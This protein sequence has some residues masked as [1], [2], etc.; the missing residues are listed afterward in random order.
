MKGLELSRRFFEELALPRLEREEPDLLARAAFGLA[1]EGSECLGF[2][3]E[4]SRD[5]DWGPG[6]CIWLDAADMASLGDRAAAFYASLP[7]AYLGCER[8]RETAETAGRVGVRET[9][10]FY[11]RYLGLDRAP[12]DLNEWFFAPEEGLSTAVSGA[13]F[14]D[15]SGAFTAIRREILAYYPEDIR[16]K[17]LAGRCALAAQAGQYN[18]P[19]C[20]R[21]GE[22]VAAM[23]ALSQF[24]E[25]AMR[26]VF[27]LNRRYM[28]YYKWAHRALREL[29]ADRPEMRTSCCPTR[30]AC[31]RRS[32]P[33]PCAVCI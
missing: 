3:D 23:L 2:D 4:L 27:L 17:K 21:R 19:R 8:L 18:Y 12:R 9:G 25:Q 6:F 24:A 11:R 7:R 22:G 32:A 1:G 16:L 10:A 33:T 5:H 29:Q 30:S 28:P 26:A 13:V 14:R 15:D 31:R 20:L